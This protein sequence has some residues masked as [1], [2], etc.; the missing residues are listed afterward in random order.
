[1]ELA[2]AAVPAAVAP[3]AAIDEPPNDDIVALHR[4]Q[5]SSHFLGLP[6]ASANADVADADAAD[7]TW[8]TTKSH[9][10]HMAEKLLHAGEHDD[11]TTSHDAKFH[12]AAREDIAKKHYDKA[13]MA[14]IMATVDDAIEAQDEYRTEQRA[15]RVKGRN[16][17]RSNYQLTLR[18][19]V[20]LPGGEEERQLLMPLTNS[21]A[22]NDLLK[23]VTARCGPELLPESGFSLAW[24]G[25]SGE[26]NE[27][28][29][30]G[31]S[32]FVAANWCA[33]PWEL[34]LLTESAR[35][36]LQRAAVVQSAKALFRKFDVNKNGWIERRELVRL[37]RD[38]RL[39]RLHIPDALVQRFIEGE[40]RRLDRDA[41]GTI[42]LDEFTCYV[43]RMT[44]WM[45]EELLFESNA[46]EIFHV[47]ASQARKKGIARTH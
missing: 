27:L 39:E 30:L 17:V 25:P 31:W 28:S 3:V 40:F 38:L 4:R 19:V 12:G 41:S 37:V 6:P 2:N 8:T 7:E 9:R 32:A 34:H 42:D 5:M 16:L 11:D 24:I 22:Y 47:L 23:A 14:T 43:G 36:K 10:A 35:A 13:S 46:L 18:L 44:R 26:I 45:R 29:Q 33:L 20:H 1:M 15:E 21:I